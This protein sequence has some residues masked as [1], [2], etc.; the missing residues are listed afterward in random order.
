MEE[1]R[2][3]NSRG[4]RVK[5][6]QNNIPSSSFLF[7]SLLFSPHTENNSP[8]WLRH[9]R[10]STAVRR[11]QRPATLEAQKEPRREPSEYRQRTHL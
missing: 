9:P 4:V 3:N 7:S 6:I 8:W 2:K 5:N 11:R 10:L 1:H